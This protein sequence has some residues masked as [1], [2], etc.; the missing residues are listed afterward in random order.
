M[1]IPPGGWL[2]GS[3]MLPAA[4]TLPPF[5]FAVVA[6]VVAIAAA[7]ALGSAWRAAS[8]RG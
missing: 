8:R 4:Q 2:V 5:G 6:L 3:A 7:L 1:T